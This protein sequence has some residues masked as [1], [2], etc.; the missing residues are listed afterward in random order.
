MLGNK[1]TMAEN[2]RK[3]MKRRGITRQQLCD[4]IDVKYTTLCN[5]LQGNSYPRI[6]KIEKMANYF[7]VSKADLVE[8]TTEENSLVLTEYEKHLLLL[9]RSL[10]EIDQARIEERMKMMLERQ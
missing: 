3:Y 7:G 9:F 2:I 4:E 6:D 1:E 10:P 8:E 5:W